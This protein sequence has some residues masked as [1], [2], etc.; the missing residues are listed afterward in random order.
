MLRA[1]TKDFPAEKVQV[2]DT[3]VTRG[4]VKDTDEET[5]EIMAGVIEIKENPRIGVVEMTLEMTDEFLMTN[6]S[7]IESERGTGNDMGTVS[8]KGTGEDPLVALHHL[9]AHVNN[10]QGLVRLR[11]L[12]PNLH[13]P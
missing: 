10:Q 12:V 9:V 13:L 2:E 3:I 8:G 5:K 1:E 4:K 6:E 11:T 7:G